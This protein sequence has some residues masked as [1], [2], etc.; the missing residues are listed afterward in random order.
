MVARIDRINSLISRVFSEILRKEVS[1][2]ESFLITIDTVQTTKDLSL[3]RVYLSIFPQEKTQTVLEILTK[4]KGFLQRLLFKKVK[5]RKTPQI[6]FL[7]NK[8]QRK[9]EKIEQILEKLKKD[10]ENKN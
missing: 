4:K 10:E 9:V 6:I 8:K 7:E 5:L 2:G 3:C 1:W